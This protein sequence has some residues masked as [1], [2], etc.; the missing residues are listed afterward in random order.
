MSMLASTVSTGDTFV[1]LG[2]TLLR[3]S[4]IIDSAPAADCGRDRSVRS[5]PSAAHCDEGGA[6]GN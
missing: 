5:M 4:G 2:L 1:E 6:K 3:A